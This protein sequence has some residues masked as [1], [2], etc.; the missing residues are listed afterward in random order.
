[1]LF[2]SEQMEKDLR[3]SARKEQGQE[4]TALKNE[5]LKEQ[6]LRRKMELEKNVIMNDAVQLHAELMKYNPPFRPEAYVVPQEFW[7]L[8]EQPPV[9]M[10]E[11]VEGEGQEGRKETKEEKWARKARGPGMK[12]TGDYRE[13]ATGYQNF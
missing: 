13:S 3:S 12:A 6:W 4:V 2:Q 5:V 11:E 1:M 9:V 10:E 8:G 7:G